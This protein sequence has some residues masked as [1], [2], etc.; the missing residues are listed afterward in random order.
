MNE[1]LSQ[2]VAATITN[3]QV[4]HSS[5]PEHARESEL[6]PQTP[7]ASVANNSMSSLP[8]H[9]L[10]VSD[11]ISVNLPQVLATKN[12]K[13][14]YFGPSTSQ[15]CTDVN[16][17]D[18]GNP[19]LQEKDI[20]RVESILELPKTV[21]KDIAEQ[22]MHTTPNKVQT[23][24]TNNT[25][26]NSLPSNSKN[27][28]EEN[29]ESV[30]ESTKTMSKDFACSA[31]NTIP[32][33]VQNSESNNTI[34][35]PVPSKPQ[36]T[37]EENIPSPFKRALFW[38]EPEMKKRRSKERLP[39]A[40]TGETWRAYM[41]KKE[42][43]K[44]Q[45]EEEKNKKRKERQEKQLIK[46]TI[47][48]ET[49]KVTNKNKISKTINTKR[50]RIESSSSSAEESDIPYQESDQD[51]KLSED[52]QINHPKQRTESLESDENIL[53]KDISL[54][55]LK[56]NTYIIV[57]YEGKYFPGLIK[58]IDK[59]TYKIST[60]VLSRG[61]TFRWPDK[62]DQIWYN[63]EVIMEK[64]EKPKSINNRDFFKVPE[65]EKYLPF[66]C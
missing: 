17:N 48:G 9:A 60:M 49:K 37:M 22:A 54:Q 44:K 21:S 53:L 51:L 62:P 14:R 56:K 10:D 20:G 34:S 63:R 12:M 47:A 5:E 43:E 65:M 45:K 57:K 32:N 66:I 16:A 41:I 59:N 61:N 58:N 3:G 19:D 7:E 18:D 24:K 27:I 40:I 13:G 28:I 2:T 4:W 55:L 39:S 31:M 15:V 26:S 38:P 23:S 64:I 29:I 11:H 36:N 30:T 25:T 1:N 46:K 52:D 35:K 6:L 42:N 33:K 50:K 8:E